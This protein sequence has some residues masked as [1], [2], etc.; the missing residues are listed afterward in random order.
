M[1]LETIFFPSTG[2]LT[3]A[4]TLHFPL[5]LSRQVVSF[6]PAFN[7]VFSSSFILSRWFPT[8][9]AHPYS[10]VIF[11]DKCHIWKIIAAMLF[12]IY[13][14][15]NNKKQYFF[16][17]DSTSCKYQLNKQKLKG[18]CA[19]CIIVLLIVFLHFIQSCVAA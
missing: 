3:E 16:S 5:T 19:F 4:L 6:F 2:T 9:S 1:E 8:I 12:S 17:H 10:V 18:S 14:L 15:N 7:N 13:P 11:E